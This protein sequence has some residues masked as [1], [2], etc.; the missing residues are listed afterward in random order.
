MSGKIFRAGGVLKMKGWVDRSARNRVEGEGDK[1][2]LV[3]MK[4]EVW[5]ETLMTDGTCSQEGQ[6]G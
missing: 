2:M 1:E 3:C 6:T 4:F 5:R